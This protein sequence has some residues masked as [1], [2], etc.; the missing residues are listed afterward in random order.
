M[1]FSLVQWAKEKGMINRNSFCCYH[2]LG[3]EK[4]SGPPAV[5]NTDQMMFKH[6]IYFFLVTLMPP[7]LRDRV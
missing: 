3:R 7:D 1:N 4:V 2:E 6:F 5:E